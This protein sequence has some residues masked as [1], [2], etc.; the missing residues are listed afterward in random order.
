MTDSPD[1]DGTFEGFHAVDKKNYS[2]SY[3]SQTESMV[4]S[5]SG[6]QSISIENQKQEYGLKVLDQMGQIYDEQMYVARGIL[7]S[8]D[9]SIIK[10]V[11]DREGAKVIA[12]FLLLSSEEATRERQTVVIKD[13]VGPIF[14]DLQVHIKEI[15]ESPSVTKIAIM[16]LYPPAQC[17]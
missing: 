11:R 8:I 16:D 14:D 6:G 10:A 7:S 17:T 4:S 2:Q 9:N 13:F 3:F 1:E 15:S 5:L 12:G